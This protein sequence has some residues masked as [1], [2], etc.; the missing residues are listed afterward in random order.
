MSKK[1][2]TTT[3]KENTKKSV[4]T[5][6]EK[7]TPP[8]VEEVV[9]ATVVEQPDITK[10]KKNLVSRNNSDLSADG[11]VKLLD[12][13]ARFF[14]DDPHASDKYGTKV[15]D[16]MNKLTAVGI[17][18]AMADQA[19][20]GQTAIGYAFSEPKMYNTLSEVASE[21]GIHLPEIKKLPIIEGAPTLQTDKIKVDKEVKE[22]LKVE[23]NIQ[24][25]GDE[26][27]IEIDPVKVAHMSEDDLKKALTYILI[28]SFKHDKNIKESLVK[29]VDFMHDYRIELA[30]QA[31]NATE[32]MN[33]Y[34]DRTMKDW[35]TDIFAYVKPTVYMKG[36]GRGMW[37]LVRK[38]NSPLSAFLIFRNYLTNKETNVPEWDD[39]SIADAVYILVKMICDMNIQ[40]ETIARDNLD[41]KK[42]DYNDLIK[43]HNEQ[44]KI[45]KQI[46]N[47]ITDIDFSILDTFDVDNPTKV[48]A[49]TRILE[50]YYNDAITAL[51]PYK[52]LH[53]NVKL[54]GGIILNLFRPAGDKNTIY[55]ADKLSDLIQYTMDEWEALQ[56]SKNDEK[57]AAKKAAS[58]KA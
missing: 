55:T 40:N 52:N 14:H 25:E 5:S 33:K 10:M 31:Q 7:T 38:E 45:N 58:K 20:N 15:V 29:A 36:I 28:T 35:L 2:I 48:T 11:Q 19:T 1:N 32:A 23:N 13:A 51:P 22:A 8:V 41:K 49:K 54:Q 56:K 4:A 46:I 6:K 17:I 3:K 24:K 42:K 26:G 39:Q 57:I 53:E 21:M 34:E 18:V 50:Q 16:N 37:E 30:R 43:F 9:D 12:L 44:I 47:N 27:S